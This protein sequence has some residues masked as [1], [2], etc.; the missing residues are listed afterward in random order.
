MHVIGTIILSEKHDLLLVPCSDA[1]VPVDEI[2]KMFTC[3]CLQDGMLANLLAGNKSVLTNMCSA[4]WFSEA[5]H[6]HK[7]TF[8]CCQSAGE[9]FL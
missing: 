3:Y 1:V 9:V 7:I 5:I 4:T 2:E 8:D 6:M